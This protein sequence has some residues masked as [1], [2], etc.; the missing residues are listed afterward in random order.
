MPNQD[1]NCLHYTY[2]HVEQYQYY[3]CLQKYMYFGEFFFSCTFRCIVICTFV[4]FRIVQLW[5]FRHQASLANK[6]IFVVSTIIK[7]KEFHSG[8]RSNL[9]LNNTK[10]SK[11]Y[12][13]PF[14]KKLCNSELLFAVFNFYFDYAG[15]SWPSEV[16]CYSMEQRPLA[17]DGVQFCEN[18]GQRWSLWHYSWRHT[19]KN[20]FCWWGKYLCYCWL[21]LLGAVSYGRS[22]LAK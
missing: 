2:K 22:S 21:R 11:D 8:M 12:K 19:R 18:R 14:E 4:A 7:K 13:K 17:A 3:I 20:F 10:Y 16:F 9:Y 5:C 1:E 15:G 6:I